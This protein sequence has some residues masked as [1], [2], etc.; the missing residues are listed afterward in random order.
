[1]LV[2]MALGGNALLRR[3]EPLDVEVQR[4]NLS[5][6]VIRAIAPI[7]RRHQVVITHGN[8]PQ[9]GLLALQAAAYKDVKPYPLDVLG[10]ESQGMIG[11]LIGQSLANELPGREIA[12]LLTQV[13]VDPSDPAFDRPTKPIGPLYDEAEAKMLAARTSCILVRD[14]HGFRR[15]VPSPNPRRIHEIEA[16]RLLVRAGTLVICA[17]GGGI[18]IVKNADGAIR[19]VEAVID[20]DLSAALLAEEIGADALLL[21]ERI[22]VTFEHSPRAE[23]SSCILVG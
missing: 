4:R 8:G 7:A 2:V 23:R 5:R 16:I 20:K 17:G 11:Y 21:L 19:G 18:P 12:T 15:A 3:G 14:G 22:P 9:I 13:E 6:A 1:M 10:A